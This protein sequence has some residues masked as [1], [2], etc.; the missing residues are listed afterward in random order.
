MTIVDNPRRA[1]FWL[2]KPSPLL[3]NKPPIDLLKQDRTKEVMDAARLVFDR[4]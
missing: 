2:S 1:W 3:G 4:P